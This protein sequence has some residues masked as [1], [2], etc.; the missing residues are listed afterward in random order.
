MMRPAGPKRFVVV[1]GGRHSNLAQHGFIT[2]M[3]DLL[4]NG[5]D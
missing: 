4:R 2:M 3:Q 1:P 5:L